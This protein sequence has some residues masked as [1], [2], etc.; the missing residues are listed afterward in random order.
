MKVVQSFGATFL[1]IL[2]AAGCSSSEKK[3]T[4]VMG[5]HYTTIEFDKGQ[6]TL[7]RE[8]KKLLQ[9]LSKKAHDDNRKIEEIRILAWSD[10]EYPDPSKQSAPTSE[11]VL[12]SNRANEIKE[13]LEN[14]LSEYED[15][16][17]YNMARRPDFLSKL[18]RDDEYAVKK[19]FE[20][21]GATGT[22][23]T[24]GRV[25][26]SKASKALVIIDYEGDEDNL[27]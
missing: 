10:K 4:E 5:T 2:F 19:A 18:L 27:Q 17:S 24:D 1:L 13:Y 20:A 21:S 12:A 16:D 25:S 6:S 22:K 26:Y 11:I 9:S 7:S 3:S 23:L 8:D 15:I 14:D